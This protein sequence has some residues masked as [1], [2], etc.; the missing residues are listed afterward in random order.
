VAEEGAVIVGHILFSVVQLDS[1]PELLSL[2]PMA[3]TPERQRGAVGSALVRRGLEL[4]QDTAYPLVVV[5]GHPAYYPRF[6]FEPARSYGIDTPYEA[7]DEAWMALPLPR[8]D[9]RIRGTVA[10]PPAWSGV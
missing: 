8:Y 7:P 6:G 2:G 4:A 10:Y 1:G 5:L 9:E 3:V